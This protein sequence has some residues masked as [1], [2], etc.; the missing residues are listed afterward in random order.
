MEITPLEAHQLYTACDET[1]FDFNSTEELEPVPNHLGQERAKDAIQFAIDISRGGYN[2]YVAGPAGIGKLSLVRD[3]LDRHPRDDSAVFDWCYINNFEEPGKPQML[4]LEKG[5]GRQL[6]RDMANLVERLLVTLPATFQSDEYHRRI[7]ELQEEYHEREEELFTSLGNQARDKGLTLMRTATGYTIAP[8][9]EGKLVT[10]AEFNQLPREAQEAIKRNID[11]INDQLKQS[12]R[13][14]NGWQEESVQRVKALNKGFI[15]QAIEP[16][17]NALKE[18]YRSQENVQRYLEGVHADI[19]ENAWDF[20]PDAGEKTATPPKAQ[21]AR[22]NRYRVNVLVD[23]SDSKTAPVVYLDQPTLQNLVGRIEH[24]AKQGTLLTNFTLIQSGALHRANGGFLIIDAYQLLLNGFSWSALKRVLKS[25]QI[26]I[27]SIN[28][29]LS[30]SSTTTLD[31]EPIPA[32]LKVVL[33]GDRLLYYLLKEYDPDFG[34]LF[35]VQADLSESIDRTLENCARYARIVGMISREAGLLP[36]SAGGVAQVIEFSARMVEHS[37]KLTLHMTRLSDL[38]CKADHEA[39]RDSSARVERR[40]VRA[41]LERWLWHGSRYQE[42]IQ[43]LIEE[44]TLMIATSG[45]AVA[46][47]NGLSVVQLGDFYFGRPSRITATARLGSGKII[48]IER[49][50]ELGGGLHSKGVMIISALLASLYAREAP[51]ALSGTLVF[52]QSYGAIEGDSASVAELL[53]L[54]SAIARIPLKQS[55]AVTGSINQLGQ[56]QAIG[57]VN[58]KVEG[59]FDVCKAR[60]LDGSHGV[61]IPAANVR[62]LMLRQEVVEACAAG[63]FAIYPLKTLSDAIALFSGLPAGEPDPQG[64]YPEG[65]FNGRLMTQLERFGTLRRELQAPA[66]A[67]KE[68]QDSD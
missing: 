55:L 16:A 39:R 38:I 49:E 15:Q 52:E 51:L 67:D 42:L 56:V 50:S 64:T 31:P 40:H 24:I 1:G 8:L 19:E 46:Q 36:L 11:E 26:R 27:E 14:I 66:A 23:N 12:V 18:R 34:L 25:G 7:N 59:F 29:I 35:K 53:V 37:N 65:S 9:R 48:D 3:I 68:Q 30:L 47:V 20:I 6:R 5:L 44:G 28:E 57:G 45:T 2:L 21:S 62:H 43:E 41:A 32:N 22:F 54:L 63:R 58:E 17:V 4:Q 61:A 13:T 60:G 10:P 33:C